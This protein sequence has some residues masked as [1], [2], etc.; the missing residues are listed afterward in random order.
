[1]S[2]QFLEGLESRML[3][4]SSLPH[5]QDATVTLDKAIVKGELLKFEA[6]ILITGAQLKVDYKGIKKT[7]AAGDTSLTADFTQLKTDFASQSSQLKTDRL[8]ESSAALADES[9]IKADIVQIRKDKGNASALIADHAQLRADRVQ[10]ETDLVAGINSRIATRQSFE[11]TLSNDLAKIQ[12]DATADTKGST[13]FET[14]VTAYVT[15]GDARLTLMVNDLTAIATAR[16]NL[17]AAIAA[18]P[19]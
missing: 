5:Y 8:A 19:S 14:A 18:E 6:D 2:R 16:D 1:M 17:A 11:T 12:T 13:A 9:K 15:A 4:S 10:L 7:T 3:M